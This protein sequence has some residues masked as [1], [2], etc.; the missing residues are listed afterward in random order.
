MQ[1]N[2]VIV[3]GSVRQNNV[4]S[5]VLHQVMDI[6]QT[7]YPTITVEVADLGKLD[8]PF[9]DNPHMPAHPEFS[10]DDS[11]V[12]EWTKLIE[13]ADGILFLTPE[14]N[15][16]LSAVQKNAIDW[17]YKQWNGKPVASIFYGFHGGKWS[18]QNLSEAMSNVKATLLPH[19]ARLYF[20]KDIA[21]DGT[22]LDVAAVNDKLTTTIAELVQA[23]S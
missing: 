2:I 15:H 1:K 17:I 13:T 6:M 9:F 23:A 21:T 3:P 7:D 4:A 12:Q 16:N 11:R 22:P 8:L 20:T 5:Q 10:E 14:Y 18:L 19:Y